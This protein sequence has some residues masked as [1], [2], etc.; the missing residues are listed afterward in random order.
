QEPLGQTAKDI[1]RPARR[2][3]RIPGV[4]ELEP[5]PVRDDV[6]VALEEDRDSEGLRRFPDHFRAFLGGVGQS[7]AT[8][9]LE[10]A[11]VRREDRLLTHEAFWIRTDR[12]DRISAKDPPQADTGGARWTRSM[13][14][15][16]EPTPTRA[17]A[18]VYGPPAMTR[19]RP[20]SPLWLVARGTG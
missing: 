4:V 15:P 17:G 20:F 13:R 2:H 14:M 16:R 8:E 7:L 1:G 5:H 19:R 11:G 18:P 9:E 10:L 3:P 6:H 12:R